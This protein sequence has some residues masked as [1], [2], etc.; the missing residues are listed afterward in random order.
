MNT[1]INRS[2]DGVVTDDAKVQRRANI[3]DDRRFK[4]I[5]AAS[6]EFNRS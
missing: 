2:Q 3:L 1:S 6:K 4:K 5:W